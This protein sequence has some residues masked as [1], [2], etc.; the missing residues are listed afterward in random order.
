MAGTS[1]NSPSRATRASGSD[2]TATARTRSSK[3]GTDSDCNGTSPSYYAWYEFYPAYLVNFS[4]AVAP[5]DTMTA[6]VKDAN[7]VITL[8]ISDTSST[9]H[10]TQVVTHSDRGY[11]LSSAEWVAEAPSSN[12]V[13][14]LAN[15]GTVSFSGASATGAGK[16]GQISAFNYDPMTMVTSAGQ[17]KASP[18]GLAENGSSSSFSVQWFHS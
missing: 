10:W 18:S 2:S 4:N 5:G 6:E 3:T 12:T 8:T 1:P 7:G 17:T 13:L 9:G 16:T 11:K 14:P 15:F